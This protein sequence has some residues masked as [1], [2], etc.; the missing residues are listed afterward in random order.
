MSVSYSHRL[1]KMKSPISGQPTISKEE[2]PLHY[3][4]AE[5]KAIFMVKGQ[6]TYVKDINR[7]G[8]RK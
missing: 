8:N 1:A 7:Q 6:E 4:E 2:G 3:D 5:N